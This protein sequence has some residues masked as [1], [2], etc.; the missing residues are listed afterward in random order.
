MACAS[1]L[2]ISDC[3]V[4]I[5]N[6]YSQLYPKLPPP[7]F[8]ELAP[9]LHIQSLENNEIDALFAYEPVLSTGIVKFKFRKIFPSVYGSQFSPNP[10][11]VAGVNT[12]W[13]NSNMEIATKYFRVIDKAIDFIKNNPDESRIIL[14]KATNIE[15]EVAK[16]MNILPLSKSKEID[17]VNL[18]IYISVL[19]DLKEIS[20][21]V[22]AVD[23]CIK[24]N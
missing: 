16:N 7:I 11:G 12:T 19:I 21:P 23:I 17:M 5:L 8:I 14:A 24:Q 6:L 18:D 15:I 13:Y 3:P 9:S 22:K 1:L 10:I 20:T 4:S 2:L